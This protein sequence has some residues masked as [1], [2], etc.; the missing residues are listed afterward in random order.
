MLVAH[1]RHPS[2]P[3]DRPRRGP[4]CGFPVGLFFFILMEK[5]PGS[6]PRHFHANL[7]RAERDEFRS[8]FKEAWLYFFFS[9]PVLVIIA[10]LWTGV[11]DLVHWYLTSFFQGMQ[12]LRGC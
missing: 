10:Y 5:L 2:L 1:L 6:L 4:T 9:R 3:G 8:K 12:A 7:N 11:P